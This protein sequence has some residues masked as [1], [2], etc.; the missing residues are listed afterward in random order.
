MFGLCSVFWDI[1]KWNFY[2]NVGEEDVK[3]VVDKFCII[4]FVLYILNVGVVVLRF[5]WINILRNSDL[6][7]SI[8]YS[9]YFGV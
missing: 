9:Y 1:K 7:Y 2:W 3:V 4:K 5:S 8:Y 6:C